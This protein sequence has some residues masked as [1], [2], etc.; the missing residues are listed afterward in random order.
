MKIECKWDW[1]REKSGDIGVHLLE[2][3]ISQMAKSNDGFICGWHDCKHKPFQY[4]SLLSVHMQ[5]HLTRDEQRETHKE[6][7]KQTQQETFSS[8]VETK[9]ESSFKRRPLQ[10]RVETS[11]VEVKTDSNLLKE[12]DL[13]KKT[14]FCSVCGKGFKHKGNLPQHMKI[15][16]NQRD[17]VCTVCGKSFI[18]KNGLVVHMR[19]HNDEKIYHCRKCGK[20]FL[21]LSFV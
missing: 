21:T 11:N 8:K 17:H 14:H 20:G 9:H 3:H 13:G 2:Q 15:H 18:Q 10:T 1:C 7:S 4:R 5:S 12:N 16:T 19:G 6:E